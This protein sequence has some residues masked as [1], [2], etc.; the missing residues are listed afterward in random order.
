MIDSVYRFRMFERLLESRIRS[1]ALWIVFWHRFLPCL[2]PLCYRLTV[3]DRPAEEW[4]AHFFFC[5]PDWTLALAVPHTFFL[6]LLISFLALRPTLG[7]VLSPS[8]NESY[9][10]INWIELRRKTHGHAL[11]EL[12]LNNHPECAG[13]ARQLATYPSEKCFRIKLPLI[14]RSVVYECK[15]SGSAATELS[16]QTED[17]N[18]IAIRLVRLGK[19]RL[20]V[21]LWDI[22]NLWVDE[23]DVLWVR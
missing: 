5:F 3:R 15:S 1:N 22:G 9:I 14:F 18:F 11:Y 13:L 7:F 20:D 10:V 6:L 8:Y 21:C 19:A 17:W 12:V 4:A 23:R 16:L 2:K